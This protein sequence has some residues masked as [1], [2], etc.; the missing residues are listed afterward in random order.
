MQ[1]IYVQ[2]LRICRQ[3]LCPTAPALVSS[4]P[5][6]SRARSQDQGTQRHYTRPELAEHA[7]RMVSAGQATAAGGQKR[8][9]GR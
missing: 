1:M 8:R 6:H 2:D 4:P 7:R 3:T 9:E 5:S